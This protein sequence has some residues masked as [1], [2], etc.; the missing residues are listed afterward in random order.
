MI[1]PCSPI[2]TGYE[3]TDDIYL[4]RSIFL[5]ITYSHIGLYNIDDTI[6]CI[7]PRGLHTER[8]VVVEGVTIFG[9]TV[10]DSVMLCPC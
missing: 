6:G 9:R 10:P 4:Y 2:L 3:K 5:C 7:V 8:L 1:G